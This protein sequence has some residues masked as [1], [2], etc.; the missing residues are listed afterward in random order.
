MLPRPSTTIS[1][2]GCRERR[3]KSAWVTTEPSGSRR[4]RRPS[5]PE[6]MSRRPSGIQSMQNGDE[7][8]LAMTSLSPARSTARSSCAP[9]SENQRRSSCQRGD[10]PKAMPVIKVCGA[11]IEDP[12]LRI[13]VGEEPGQHRHEH[14][15]RHDMFLA[16]QAYTSVPPAT[17]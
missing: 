10:S 17:V 14:L 3:L 16:L 7:D 13:L 5:P 2:Q 15:G 4:R 6:T 9:Q 8:T 1:F 11:G 12:F